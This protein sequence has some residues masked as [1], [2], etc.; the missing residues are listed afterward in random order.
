MRSGYVD[1]IA[2]DSL[3][4]LTP[5]KEIEESVGKDHMGVGA[6]MFGQAFRK[7]VSGF[8]ALARQDVFPVVLA[9]N[10]IRMDLSVMFGN[11]ETKP[12]GKA[13]AFAAVSECRFSASK[14]HTNTKLRLT[15]YA[16]GKVIVKKNKQG[17]PGRKGEFAIQFVNS[18]NK[19]R[20]D[21]CDEALML[22]DARHYGLAYQPEGK[23]GWVVLDRTFGKL[24]DI[25]ESWETDLVWKLD[26]QAALLEMMR[27]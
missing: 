19:T 3:A 5:Q 21:V 24:E 6:R 25:T 8:K 20:G 16:E 1:M 27:P 13:P 11:P 23:K 2:L 4:F 9:T 12:G 22:S 10:Q 26:C 14:P 15:D 18:G 17:A 7:F